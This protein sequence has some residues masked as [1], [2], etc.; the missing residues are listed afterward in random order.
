M[1]EM[2]YSNGNWH[3]IRDELLLVTHFNYTIA[4][5]EMMAILFN[6][7]AELININ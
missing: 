2:I 4:Y 7:E 1:I 5:E 6:G 3:I